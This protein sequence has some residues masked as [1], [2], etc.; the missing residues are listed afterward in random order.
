MIVVGK[1]MSKEMRR[2]HD[3]ALK[4]SKEA[5]LNKMRIQQEKNAEARGEMWIEAMNYIE[6]YSSSRCWK[7]HEQA[8]EEYNKLD[9]ESKRLKAVK[10]QI[11]IRRKGFGWEDAGHNW[12][13][14]GYT[15]TSREL[16]D[17]FINTVLPM[18]LDREIPT[19][20]QLTLSVIT[21]RFKLGTVANQDINS[22][23]FNSKTDEQFKQ[24]MVDERARREAERD[25]DRASRL[26]SNVMPEFGDN[27]VGF[28]IEFCFSYNAEDGSN[29]LAWIEGVIESIVNAKQRTVMIRWNGEKV[30]EGDL[31]VSKHTLS[32]RRWNPKNAQE[33]AWREYI[34][35]L[36]D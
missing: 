1:R 11:S 19:E 34:G 12:S 7:S 22:H 23:T 15:F 9:S 27:L 24:E 3:D 35:D 14:D 16:L 31:L 33:N 6:Q 20:P 5:K 21:D 2:L 13:K 18:E 25:T 26:Q 29:Y 28:R 36:N 4:T 10:E 8:I 30:A 17:H 32:K